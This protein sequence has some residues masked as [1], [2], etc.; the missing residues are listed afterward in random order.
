MV[1]FL[2]KLSSF[3]GTKNNLKS[4][5]KIFKNKYF[6]VITMP[7]EKENVFGFN[8]C[9]KS[10]KMLYIIYADIDSLIKKNRWICK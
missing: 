5:E 8:Q 4:H 7:S 3:F 9:V 2:F 6:Y 10:D 1:I